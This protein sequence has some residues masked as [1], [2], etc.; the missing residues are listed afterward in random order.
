MFMSPAPVATAPILSQPRA[1]TSLSAGPVVVKSAGN[2]SCLALSSAAVIKARPIP[3]QRC[4]GWTARPVS[5]A[6]GYRSLPGDRSLRQTHPTGVPALSKA[7]SPRGSVVPVE[8]QP[9]RSMP[10]EPFPDGP[11]QSGHTFSYSATKAGTAA[12]RSSSGRI[13]QARP[14]SSGPGPLCDTRLPVAPLTCRSTR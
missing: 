9:V 14:G 11:Y 3:R 4:S 7:T 5:H 12:G 10:A 1:R 13:R 6:P 8:R 2:P